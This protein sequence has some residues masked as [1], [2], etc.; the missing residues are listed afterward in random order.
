MQDTGLNLDDVMTFCACLVESGGFG[1]TD[2]V[3]GVVV[4]NSASSTQ[5]ALPGDWIV[6]AAAGSLK[7]M[8]PVAFAAAYELAEC[9]T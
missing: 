7:G 4:M 2:R 9:S 1:F 3:N 8:K 6:M 5:R